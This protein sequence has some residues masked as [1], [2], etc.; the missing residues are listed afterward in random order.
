M[1]IL[2]HLAFLAY[3]FRLN[4]SIYLRDALSYVHIWQAL[5][6]YWIWFWT[7][8]WKFVQLKNMYDISYCGREIEMTQT[9]RQSLVV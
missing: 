2:V 1:E 4:R 8:G 6:A 5:A 7:H 3:R 9:Y